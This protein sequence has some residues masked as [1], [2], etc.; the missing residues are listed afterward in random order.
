[1]PHGPPQ[2]RG[3]KGDSSRN[4]MENGS[5]SSR[6]K[7]RSLGGDHPRSL[8]LDQRL[9]A[10]SDD[11]ADLVKELRSM[12]SSKSEPDITKIADLDNCL[13]IFKSPSN[14]ASSA[15]V[16]KQCYQKP[17]KNG[18]CPLSNSQ[19]SEY[20]DQ[21]PKLEPG[22]TKVKSLLPI[23]KSNRRSS[24]NTRQIAIFKDSK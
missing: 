20:S 19:M 21:K 22:S 16:N 18:T 24:S 5:S 13:V 11:E 9:S 15:T 6:N 3:K 7:K 10:C 8:R 17:H 4:E 2:K 12:C 23:P 14:E 1:M